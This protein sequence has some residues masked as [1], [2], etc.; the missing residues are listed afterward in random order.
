MDDLNVQ[1]IMKKRV[2]EFDE[3]PFTKSDAKTIEQYQE[4]VR[5]LEYKSISGMDLVPRIRQPTPEKK[6]PLDFTPR[7]CDGC[8]KY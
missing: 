8:T 5:Y 2:T 3:A 6:D 4:G 1:G 7:D